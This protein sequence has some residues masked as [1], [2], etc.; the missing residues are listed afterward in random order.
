[1]AGGPT[2]EGQAGVNPADVLLPMDEDDNDPGLS[3][4]PTQRTLNQPKSP[5]IIP[6]RTLLFQSNL[7]LQERVIWGD[8]LGVRH[9]CLL[10]SASEMDGW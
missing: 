9:L 4:V 10:F 1:V 3:R 2:P 6:L 8:C 5:K 7:I